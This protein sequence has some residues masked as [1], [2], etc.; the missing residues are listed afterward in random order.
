MRTLHLARWAAGLLL[1]MAVN[2]SAQTF[3]NPIFELADPFV[4]YH[5]GYYYATGTTGWS[6]GIKKSR[7]LEGLKTAGTAHV[8]RAN[9]D[10]APN[11]AYW[12]SELHRIDGKWYAYFTGDC[13]DDD[14]GGHHRL[15]VYENSSD[16][17]TTGTWVNRGKI[18]DTDNDVWAIDGT[19]MEYGGQRYFL[20]SGAPQQGI[21]INRMTNPWTLQPGRVQLSY[22][23]LDWELR[24]G[25]VNEGPEAIVHDG[26][27]FVVYSVNGCWGPY[28]QLA[29]LSLREGGDPLVASDWTKSPQPVFVGDASIGVVGPGHHCFMKSPDGQEDWFVYHATA[30]GSG[31]CD[32][33]RTCRAQRIT[34]R[35][36][37][38]PDF[39]SPIAAG[40]IMSAPSGEAPVAVGTT[41]PDGIYKIVCK[42]TGQVLDLD[43]CN[44]NLGANIQQY[45]D[46]DNDCQRWIVRG[47]PEG[48]YTLCCVSGGLPMEVIS[49]SDVNGANVQTYA[50][51]GSWGQQWRIEAD[52]DYWRVVSRSSGKVL[53]INTQ[54]GNAQQYDD[55]RGDNQRFAFEAVALTPSPA[56][57]CMTWESYNIHANY[58]RHAYGEGQISQYMTN[59]DPYWRMVPGLCGQGVSFQAKAFPNSYLRHRGGQVYLDTFEDSDLYRQDASFHVRDGLADSQY[60]SFESVNM[61]GRYLR[62]RNSLLYVEEVGDDLGRKDATFIA[63]RPGVDGGEG[64]VTVCEDALYGGVSHTLG[65][66]RYDYAQLFARGLTGMSSLRVPRGFKATLY[67]DDQFGGTQAVFEEDGAYV[68]DALNDGVRSIVVEPNGVTG[69]SGHYKIRGRSSR[70][71]WDMDG[72]GAGNDTKLVQWD[73]EGEEI[74]QGFT[75]E[76]IEPGVY[77]VH[78][79]GSEQ[80]VVEIYGASRANNANV[81]I[82]DDLGGAHQQFVLYSP[83]GGYYQFVV[84]SCGKVIEVPN[85]NLARGQVL[86]LFD[87]NGQ[88]CS[89]WELV[90]RVPTAIDTEGLGT[91]GWGARLPLG[92]DR[93]YASCPQAGDH[94][95]TIAT[96]AGKVVYE[97]IHVG[98]RF[99]V[100]VQS[101]SSGVYMVGID[102]FHTKVVKR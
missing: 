47:T 92:S 4:V 31:G 18:Y 75:L 2:A 1:A 85:D 91:G 77:R 64:I 100:S 29:M 86:Q 10:G 65:E 55:L 57:G 5:N 52:G 94:R 14:A 41:L 45:Y 46:L 3:T 30:K 81:Q 62:H 78:N 82:Y 90:E 20:Y 50:P 40:T 84:R 93:L 17:P 80:R 49:S 97:G 89:Q 28:Y 99:A 11:G 63:I 22:P 69:L 51:N 43:G 58:I 39:G 44:Q 98:S 12:A 6:V 15:F 70:L 35:A 13:Y 26:R 37:G 21:Y 8:I 54:T 76:E 23:S 60:T 34:W 9:V 25:I 36:D 56:E 27:A 68:G 7:T 95:V 19:V 79:M 72:N 96:P 33:T 87:N 61:A 16:D 66:G 38:T 67:G 102:D 32:E 101:L 53:D 73:D 71:Y 59:D 42:A 83:E 88:Y 24:D 48:Y 74:Y